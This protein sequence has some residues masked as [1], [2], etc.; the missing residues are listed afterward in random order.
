MG[1]DHALS[2]MNELVWSAL[3]ISAPVLIGTLIVGVIISV[4][5]VATQVQEITLSY[6]PKMLAAALLL[7]LFGSWMLSRVT[8]FAL[9][10]YQNISA[11]Q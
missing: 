2:L 9:G 11:L 8:Q 4:F 7:V 10:L 3:I 1:A 5:Q 6:V